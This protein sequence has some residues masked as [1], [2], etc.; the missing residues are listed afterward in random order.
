M[1]R[2]AVNSGEIFT[3]TGMLRFTGEKEN[4]IRRTFVSEELSPYEQPTKP[5]KEKTG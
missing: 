5:E 1:R 4:K 3:H 2:A